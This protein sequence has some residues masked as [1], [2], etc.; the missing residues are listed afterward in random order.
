MSTCDV[1]LFLIKRCDGNARKPF[2]SPNPKEKINLY[3][4][5][6]IPG[7]IL[8]AFSHLCFI[9]ECKKCTWML[10]GLISQVRN[11]TG[12]ADD[13]NANWR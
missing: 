1:S 5:W 12:P 4:A 8:G 13:V 11:Q 10:R 3:S 7:L 9:F 2:L 6:Y